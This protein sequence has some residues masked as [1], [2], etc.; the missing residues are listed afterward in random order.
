M[1][2]QLKM[3]R[4]HDFQLLTVYATQ[5]TTLLEM[6]AQSFNDQIV[7]NS[8][9][10]GAA[11]LEE[12]EAVKETSFLHGALQTTAIGVLSAGVPP[13]ET[14]KV[15]GGGAFDRVAQQLRVQLEEAGLWQIQRLLERQLHSRNPNLVPSLSDVALMIAPGWPWAEDARKW[16]SET[17]QLS[18]QR[19]KYAAEAMALG[20]ASKMKIKSRA[21]QDMKPHEQ[22]L[23]QRS[24]QHKRRDARDVLTLDA[25]ELAAKAEQDA[26]KAGVSTYNRGELF[27]RVSSD[28]KEHEIYRK[29]REAQVVSMFARP[30]AKQTPKIET[31]SLPVTGGQSFRSWGNQHQKPSLALRAGTTSG[32]SCRKSSAS[33]VAITG[34]GV[35]RGV[36]ASRGVSRGVSRSGVPFEPPTNFLDTTAVPECASH[37]SGDGRRT[38]PVITSQIRTVHNIRT[39][40]N[41]ENSEATPR[42]VVHGSERRL[43]AGSRLVGEGSNQGSS[44]GADAGSG[45]SVGFYSRSKTTDATPRPRPPGQRNAHMQLPGGP[46]MRVRSPRHKRAKEMGAKAS[47]LHARERTVKQSRRLRSKRQMIS[48]FTALRHQQRQA[49]KSPFNGAAIRDTFPGTFRALPKAQGL[50]LVESVV[51]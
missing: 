7:N 20:Q 14:A 11:A 24:E 29:H 5:P 23:H 40:Q 16:A 43:S 32:A 9:P 41:V 46:R 22:L 15:E 13:V 17:S 28:L 36:G 6:S 1:H 50:D 2:K 38:P 19:K 33:T 51:H 27:S 25:T 26:I 10:A 3:L 12:T 39:V 31:S 48:K 49:A 45:S 18:S 30:G 21:Q 42:D 47:R 8:Y 34:L 44:N 4:D 35:G 37:R